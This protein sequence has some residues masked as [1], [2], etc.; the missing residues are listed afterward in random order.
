MFPVP[1]PV[2][3]SVVELILQDDLCFLRT[4]GV[5]Y[6]QVVS[7]LPIRQEHQLPGIRTP[8]WRPDIGRV[9]RKSP[10][11]VALQVIGPDVSI[12]A[13]RICHIY[14]YRS[15]IWSHGHVAV[16]T[17]LAHQADLTPSTVKPGKLRKRDNVAPLSN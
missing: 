12:Q 4:I 9:E 1:G 15:S 3:G 6:K 2:V 11:A 13:A 10:R 5:L 16:R 14:G 17:R 8:N 7:T